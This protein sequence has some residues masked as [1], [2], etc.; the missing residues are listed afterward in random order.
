MDGDD[1]V[2]VVTPLELAALRRQVRPR[3][4][5]QAFATQLDVSVSAVQRWENPHLAPQSILPIMWS[6]IRVVLHLPATAVYVP[7]ADAKAS[8]AAGAAR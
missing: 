5:Q 7:S 8:R 1:K 2:M 4:S 3:L 6:A